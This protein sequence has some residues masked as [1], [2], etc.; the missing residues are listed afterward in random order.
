MKLLA[1]APGWTA[2]ADVIVV[3][4]GMQHLVMEILQKLTRKILW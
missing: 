3:G 2:T 1:P 4:S